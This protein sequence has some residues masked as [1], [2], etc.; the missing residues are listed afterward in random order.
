MNETRLSLSGD[1]L[2]LE[3]VLDS[4]TGPKLRQQG[5]QL[6]QAFDREKLVIDCSGVVKSSS[7]GLAL[8]LAFMRD[9]KAKGCKVQITGLP[10]DMTHIAEV[11]NV[12]EIM[13]LE[14]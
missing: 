14:A 9:L 7:V 1:V 3:G 8:L 5:Q 10:E 6:I 4:I 2:R 12:Q 11:S 13:Q